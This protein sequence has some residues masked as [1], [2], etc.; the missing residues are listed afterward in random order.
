MALRARAALDAGEAS[1]LRALEAD[2]LTAAAIAA[3]AAS[4]DQL[5]IRLY[6]ES[7]RAMGRAI[8][9]LVNLLSP[10]VIAVGGGMSSAGELL[11]GPLRRAV[12]EIGREVD[13]AA[14]H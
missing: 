9:G 10:E 1:T 3:A 5:S 7:G 11:F 2:Q 6:A 4:G 8:G 12:G 14:H 13:H